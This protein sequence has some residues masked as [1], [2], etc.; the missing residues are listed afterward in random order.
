MNKLIGE[1]H[2]SLFAKTIID[3]E[4]NYFVKLTPE[5]INRT[6]CNQK[7]YISLPQFDNKKI[8]K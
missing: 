2:S 5:I 4:E 8:K 1:K 3:I 6:V 7:F